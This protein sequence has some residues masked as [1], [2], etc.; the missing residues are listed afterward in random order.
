MGSF[1]TANSLWV[2]S[3]TPE[4]SVTSLN[5]SSDSQNFICGLCFFSGVPTHVSHL[6][7]RT[8]LLCPLGIS[9]WIHSKSNLLSSP[10]ILFF[11]YLISIPISQSKLETWEWSSLSPPYPICQQIFLFLLSIYLMSL[12]SSLCLPVIVRSSNHCSTW[13]TF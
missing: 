9:K 10:T 13:S 6:L 4:V 12:F 5:Y 3:F 1:L 7:P 2:I 8:L 11:T